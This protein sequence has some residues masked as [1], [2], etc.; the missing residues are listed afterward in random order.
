MYEYEILEDKYVFLNDL[1]LNVLKSKEAFNS[2]IIGYKDS[3]GKIYSVVKK[4]DSKL[5]EEVFYEAV[6]VLEEILKNY[7]VAIYSVDKS[8]IFARQ[9][10]CSRNCLE[11][12]PKSMK[13]TD[14]PEMLEKLNEKDTFV[15]REALEG[16]PAYASPIFRGEELVGMIML[17]RVEYSEMNM[18][19]LN[20]FRIITDLIKDSLIRAMEYNETNGQILK[21]T[22]ILSARQFA[23]V[24]E[25][26]KQMR[27]KQYLDYSLLLI[28]QDGRSLKEL[29]DIIAK[30]VRENDILGL[31]DNND[32]YLLLSQS[33][34]E[35][36]DIVAAR[37]KRS[38]ITFT[39]VEA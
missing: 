17:M 30:I 5:P 6:N 27:K 11:I 10:V 35:D 25:M 36:V 31:D 37:M 34:K 4:L 24:L 26:K 9:N 20:K 32:L 22:R 19:Y 29:N 18:E 13:L 38:E 14:Y 2:Q 8:K 12:L 15:N 7:F 33:K 1:Y 23:Q 16:Y 21:D 28:N 39:V 3:F